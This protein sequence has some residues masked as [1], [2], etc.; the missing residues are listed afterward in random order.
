MT[1]N[2]TFIFRHFTVGPG[3][4]GSELDVE[5]LLNGAIMCLLFRFP[6]VQLLLQFEEALVRL[7]R[8]IEVL[9]FGIVEHSNE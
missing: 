3:S 5:L 7:Y 8:E 9:L 6:I 1:L 2:A 4:H